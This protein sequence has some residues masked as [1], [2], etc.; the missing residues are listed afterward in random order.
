MLLF[1]LS[2][3]KVG[4]WNGRWTGEGRTYARARRNPDK[5]HLKLIFKKGGE[6]AQFS[7]DFAD[8]WVACIKVQKVSAAEAKK[9]LR[10]SEGFYGY[11]WMIDDIIKYGYISQITS[12]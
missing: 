8:G 9:I 3:P 7:H 5:D 10:R 12:E 1:T 6:A 11:D 2:M 4:S